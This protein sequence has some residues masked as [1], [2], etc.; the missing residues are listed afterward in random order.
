MN[1]LAAWRQSMTV[2]DLDDWCRSEAVLP[3][4]AVMLAC[5]SMTMPGHR[6]LMFV[7]TSWIP[8]TLMFDHLTFFKLNTYRMSWAAVYVNDV[9]HTNSTWGLLQALQEEWRVNPPRNNSL[10]YCIYGCRCQA[11]ITARGRHAPYYPPWWQFLIL[12]DVDFC[13]LETMCPP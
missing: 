11:V 1:N 4:S 5:F 7:G 10:L 12:C 6:L 3:F 8:T 13:I 2:T 9:F